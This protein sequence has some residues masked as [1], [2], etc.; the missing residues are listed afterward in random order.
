M[1]SEKSEDYE[2]IARSANAE[3]GV[4][5][6]FWEGRFKSQVLLDEPALLAAMADVDLN[7]I[8]AGLAKTPDK[9]ERNID[10]GTRRQTTCQSR[11]RRS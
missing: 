9:L 6:R 10:T 4:K 3:D 5:G 7:R 1:P 2:Y 8:R 11:D